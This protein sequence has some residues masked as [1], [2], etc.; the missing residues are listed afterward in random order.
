M[1]KKLLRI[2]LATKTSGASW[3]AVQL[4]DCF[5]GIEEA[6][7]ATER[8]YAE[9]AE[10]KKEVVHRLCDKSL[11]SAKKITEDCEK[12]GIDILTPEDTR[13]PKRLLNISAPVQVL[14]SLGKIPDWEEILA[15][16]IV[17]TRKYTEYGQ[18][19]T[20]RISRELAE[21]GVTVVSG[22][23][24]GIDSFALKS[25]LRVGASTVAV[26]GCGLETAYPS[27]NREL[28]DRII[29]TGCAI[30]EYPPY[31]PPQAAHFPQRNRIVS[32]ISDG[33]LAVEAPLKSG[34]L[35]TARLAMDMGRT[36]FAVPGNIFASN[37]KGTNLLIKQGAVA[38]TCAEDI[39]EA[40]PIRRKR[41]EKPSPPTEKE[42]PQLEEVTLDGLGAE[43]N[44][45]ISLLKMGDMHI[46][47]LS[48]RAD[49]TVSELNGILPMLEIDGYIVKLAGNIY[50]YNV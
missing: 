28:M 38:T 8:D 18:T 46:E 3:R 11:D 4:V 35:I 16:A 48:A 2:W 22:M 39:M 13:F 32:A 27:E 41:L 10:M 17:G 21:Q 29:E 34:T 26:M 50:K 30:S 44:K 7:R 15:V 31:S 40:F 37:S 1:D 43:E 9:L 45:I 6:Y 24:R 36:L 12:F 42:E 5:G 25:A 49:M 20:E 47:E 33:V 23:A 14:Y 19:V